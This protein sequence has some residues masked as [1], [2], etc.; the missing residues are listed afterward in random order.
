MKPKTFNEEKHQ[1]EYIYQKTKKEQSQKRVTKT[2]IKTIASIKNVT[3]N[4]VNNG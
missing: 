2:R 4:E 3:K 1:N